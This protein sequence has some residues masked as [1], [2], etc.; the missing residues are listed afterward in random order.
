MGIMSIVMLFGCYPILFVM[1]FV[2]RNAGIK[3][4]YTFGASLTSELKSDPKILAVDE[5]YRKTLKRYTIILAFLPLPSFFTSYVSI[6]F[7]IWMIWILIVCFYPMVLFAKANKK[8]LDIK[9]EYGVIEECEV[10]YTDTK[11]ASVPR[12]VKFITF[13]PTLVLSIVPVILSYMLFKEAGYMAIRLCVI[14]FGLCT[15][16]F[17]GFAVLTD[18]QKINVISEDSDTNMNYARA[19]KQLW[20]NFWLSCSWLNTIFIWIVLAGMYMRHSMFSI[21][22]WGS[23]AYGVI[24][25]LFAFGLV[26]KIGE[27]DEKYQ[28]KKNFAGGA[29]EDRFWKYG[30][31]Y[32]N[33]KDTHVMV[34]NRMGTGMSMNMATGAGRGTYIFACLCLLI[35][36]VMCIWMIMM[37]FTPISTKVEKETIICTHL[38]IE[39][40]IPLEEIENYTVLTELPEMMKVSGNGMDHVLSGTY[41]AYRVGPFEVFLNPQNDLYIKIETQEE[42]YYISGVDDTETKLLIEH[43]DQFK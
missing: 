36:P 25:T 32:Y 38:S 39:Y 23:V 27:L 3:S 6:E 8:V 7:S 29:S 31:V 43:L 22:L 42:T 13:L 2:F 34:A 28:Q 24:A 12:K 35:I 1:Y 11:I 5:A 17:Y 4:G 41:E 26:K 37:D 18:R 19:K 20:K 40:E 10:S 14:V 9:N 30:M 21:F 15:P 33:P 16:M